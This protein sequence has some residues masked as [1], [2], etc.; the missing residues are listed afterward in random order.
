MAVDVEIRDVAVQ[1]LAHDVGHVAERK[2]IARA[3]EREAVVVR[4]PFARFHF[5]ADAF[6]AAVFE[7]DLSS[8]GMFTWRM[9]K[10]SA[11][12]KTKNSTLTQPFM[13]KKAALTR[14]RSSGFTRPCS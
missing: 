8:M 4:K 9:R 2:Q 11:A 5:F 7:R 12:Q 3:V 6:Q 13:V 1:A 14:E 10:I